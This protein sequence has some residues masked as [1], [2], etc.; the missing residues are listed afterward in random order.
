MVGLAAGLPQTMPL[1]QV[2]DALSI[3]HEMEQNSERRLAFTLF[4]QLV[5]RENG[6]RFLDMARH[7]Y[8]SAEIE[9]MEELAAKEREKAAEMAHLLSIM[10]I[11]Q[12][13]ETRTNGRS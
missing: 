12:Q 13:M 4:N 11:A 9:Q 2:L 5:V 10:R 7:L 3:K 6:G 1:S 8:T